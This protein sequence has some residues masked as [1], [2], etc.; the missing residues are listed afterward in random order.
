MSPDTFRE[1][2]LR[3]IEDKKIQKQ[4]FAKAGGVTPTSLAAYL[5]GRSLPSQDTLERWVHAYGLSGTWLLTGLGPMYEFGRELAGPKKATSSPDLGDDFSAE[6]DAGQL[7]GDLLWEIVGLKDMSQEDLAKKARIPLAD[8]KNIM[9]SR[10]PPTFDEMTK[11]A[12]RCHI[13]PLYLM[14][15][16]EPYVLPR[17]LMAR[18]EYATGLRARDTLSLASSL[19]VDTED[20]RQWLRSKG[21]KTR[22]PNTW[23]ISLVRKYHLNPAWLLRGRGRT[24]LGP[25]DV[26]EA[27]RMLG[28]YA[29]QDGPTL[30]MAAEDK[31]DYGGQPA[32]PR[33]KAVGHE[34]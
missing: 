28:A 5:K 29:E 16:E 30:P 8:M 2:L 26:E 14:L 18:L 9:A 23:M 20:V 11:L 24:H 34:D 25:E 19:G 13:N 12:K 15:G 7:I 31:A 17:D 4:V 33:S 32:A 3:V 10:R 1:R 6:N 27:V 22:I 21:L